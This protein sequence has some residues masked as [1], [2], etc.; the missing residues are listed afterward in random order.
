MI[1]LCSDCSIELTPD[2]LIL[3]EQVPIGKLY[4]S[5]CLDHQIKKHENKL[6]DELVRLECEK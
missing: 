2:D 4:C 1:Y 5:D 3:C 6:I